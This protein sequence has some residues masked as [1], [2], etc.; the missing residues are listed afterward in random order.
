MAQAAKKS[1]TKANPNTRK[2]RR[3]VYQEVTDKIIAKLEQGT[4]PWRCPWNIHGAAKN[5]VSGNAYRGINAFLLNFMSPHAVP[6]YLTFKQAKTLG[7]KIR[8]GAKS[9]KVYF[10]SQ[11]NK[12]RDGKT[13][14]EQVASELRDGGQP[15]RSIPYL[16]TFS[17]FN[18]SDVE[19]IDLMLPEVVLSNNTA[20]ARCEQFLSSVANAPKLIGEDVGGA[21][22]RPRTDEINLPPLGAFSSS[23]EYYSTYFHELIHATGHVTR[24][25]REAVTGEIKPT[26][27]AYA[28]EELTAEMGAAFLRAHTRIN[29]PQ[30]VDNSAAYIADWLSHLHNDKTLVFR[31]AAQAQRAVDYLLPTE[32]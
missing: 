5:Y 10:F 17:V 7:G 32:A 29:L 23:E 25:N 20:N 24:L 9:E 8:K 28:K 14:S 4:A 22:Y 2:P 11:I 18:V 1:S 13:V 19:G 21:W 27:E 3:D 16:K 6:Y 26:G 15:V 30:V 12:D 31:A